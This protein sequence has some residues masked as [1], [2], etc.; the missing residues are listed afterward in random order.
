MIL[1]TPDACIGTLASQRRNSS[2]MTEQFSRSAIPW[3][4]LHRVFCTSC[5]QSSDLRNPDLVSSSHGIVL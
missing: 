5:G 3:N 4:G 1:F 2:E